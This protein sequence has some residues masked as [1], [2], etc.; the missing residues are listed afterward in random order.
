ASQ[1]KRDV[2]EFDHQPQ[3]NE[4]QVTDEVLKA[5][6]AFMSDFVAK[7]PEV[8]LTM[9]QVDEQMEFA[10][11]KIREEALSAAYGIDTQRRMTA[12]WDAQ[13]QRAVAELPQSAQL[14]ERARRSWRTSKK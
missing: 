3:A 2:T 9:K 11:K 1:F 5:Y 7:T 4:F 13:L 12:D 14:A 6:R 10:R 8:G